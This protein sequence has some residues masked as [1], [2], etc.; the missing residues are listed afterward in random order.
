MSRP[1][2]AAILSPRLWAIAAVLPLGAGGCL[3]NSGSEKVVDSDAK[4][5]KVDFESEEALTTFQRAV[6]ERYEAGG[7][8]VSKSG[9]AIPFV[10]AAGERR[11]LSENA[12]YNG[13]VAKAD[14]NGDGK[15]ADAE[16]RAYAQ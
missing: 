12:Y 9:F 5:L 11:V 3:I 7:G 16:A 10:I 8:V 14:A 2:S 13:E 4:R 1:K 6:R 15:I